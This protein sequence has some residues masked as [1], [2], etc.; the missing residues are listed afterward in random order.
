VSK[1]GF[2]ED[3]PVDKSYDRTLLWRLLR[4]LRPYKLPVLVSF[5]LIVA[6]AGLDLVGP[7][8]TKVAIDKYI[9]QGNASGLDFIAA[10]YLG[11]LLLAFIVRFGQVYILQMT[12]QRVM[13]DLRREIYSHLQRLHVGFFDQNPV[14]R[15]MTRVTT[16]VDAVNELFTSGVVTVFGDLFT[17]F[18]IMGVMLA[19]NWKLALVTFSVIP[20]F[21]VVTNWFRR[22][23]RATFR[24]VRRWVARINA[25]LQENITGMAV[26]QLFRR[27]PRNREAFAAI[28]RSHTD[29]NLAQIFYYAMF[30]PAIELLAALATALILLYGGWRVIAG[31]LTLGA[32][33]AFIQYS[34]RFWRPISDLSEK[35]NI[36]QAAMASSERIFTLL[37][38]E[39]RIVA[40]ASPV[41]LGRV[42]GRVGFEGVTFGYQPGA[43][44]LQDIDFAVEAGKSVALV[45]AT[46]AGKTS[47]ISLLTR[48]YD[49]QQGRV[50]LDGVDVRELDPAQLRSS[51][52]LVLQDVHLFSGTIASNIRLGSAI[53]DERVR[54]AARAVHAHRFIEALPKGYETEV[55]ERGGTLSVGQKQ[56]LSFARALAHDPRVLILDEATSSVDTETEALIQDAL[57]VLLQGRTAIVIAHRLSTIQHVDE[58]L[59]LHKGR[60][61]ER[62]T[63]QE[64]LAQRGLY[65][66]LYQLQYKDQEM[67]VVGAE[68]GGLAY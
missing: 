28:N 59:V 18:G 10:L 61:R 42:Q 56:L 48:F 66:R 44:V 22:G 27:E 63:H 2:H 62:G 37:D 40:P 5:L 6:M 32:L 13:M 4:Y 46:G 30:Y 31:T 7:Y 60:I 16:D 55:R 29:A 53:P 38:T 15:L 64:L 11:S 58:I 9:R 49:V 3:D 54:E 36:L 67:R 35:F 21:F 47:I 20:L 50:T 34:E 41:R 25:F 14:G 24:E 23:S 57:K 43:P 1:P 39:P 68:A 17:L 52:A 51:L 33:V 19:M 65:W 26:V 8:L 45:G 12:G